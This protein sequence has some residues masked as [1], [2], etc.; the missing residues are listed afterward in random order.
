MNTQEL[1]KETK[2]TGL[3]LLRQPFPKH[4]ISKLPKPTSKD[5][6]KGKCAECGGWHGLPAVHLDYV[7]HAAL[8]DR[9]LES[10]P[11]W[12]WDFVAVDAVGNPV[13]DKNGGFWINL[14]I[15]GVTRK[16]YGHADGG[17]DGDSIKEA[18]GDALRNG[19]MRF[20]AALDLWHKGDLHDSG[21]KK[22]TKVTGAGPV[23]PEDPFEYVIKMGEKNSL[24]NTKIKDHDLAY[25]SAQLE[26]TLGWY[27]DNSKTPHSNVLE[28]QKVLEK[29]ISLKMK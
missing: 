4:Q 5:N 6:P 26:K 24:T 14:T 28:F 16:G 25:L 7:G 23:I 20:G 15:C 12:T 17:T 2:L 10:D 8:T 11:A 21:E 29:A 3:Q 13:F 18:I 19:A 22:E 9:L 27:K 1:T